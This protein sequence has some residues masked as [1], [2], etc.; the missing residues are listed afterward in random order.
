MTRSTRR[1]RII[2]FLLISGVLC[3]FSFCDG[4]GAPPPSNDEA[5]LIEQKWR[6]EAAKKLKQA[7]QQRDQAEGRVQ[8]WTILAIGGTVATLV[9]GTCLRHK[10]ERDRVRHETQSPQQDQTRPSQ[11]ET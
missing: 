4:T 1:T 2:R 9:L 10:L 6:E 5:R 11:G 8:L 3:A 7:E